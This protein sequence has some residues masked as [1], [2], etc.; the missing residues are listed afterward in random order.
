MEKIKFLVRAAFVAAL[1]VVLTFISSLFGMS[2]GVIQVRLSEILCLM[3]AYTF[4]A[5]PGLFVGCM[6]ANLITGAVIYDV[7]FGSLATLIGA[8]GTYWLRKNKYL[9]SLPPVIS[10]SIIVPMVLR[11]AYGIKQA[12]WYMVLTVGIGEIISCTVLGTIVF[13]IMEKRKITDKFK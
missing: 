7:I 8:L 13:G 5:V 4:A 2:S 1:Y 9:R 3:P 6:V 11:Y 12:V 10:N